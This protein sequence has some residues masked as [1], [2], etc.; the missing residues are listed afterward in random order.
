MLR[1]AAAGVLMPRRVREDTSIAVQASRGT[2]AI[3]PRGTAVRVTLAGLRSLAQNGTADDSIAEADARP[4]DH[5]NDLFP[6]RA[7]NGWPDVRHEPADDQLD[8]F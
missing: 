6:D 5:M 8:D 3:G 7:G 4:S 2:W 1:T